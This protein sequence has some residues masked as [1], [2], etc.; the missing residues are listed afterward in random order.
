VTAVEITVMFVSSA[1]AAIYAIHRFEQLR[2][3]VENL[4]R[5]LRNRRADAQNLALHLRAAERHGARVDDGCRGAM[6]RAIAWC[7]SSPS[8]KHRVRPDGRCSVCGLGGLAANDA[9]R[10]GR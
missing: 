5:E 3:Q 2:E 6:A 4:E 9:E 10:G 1:L 8:G 7:E